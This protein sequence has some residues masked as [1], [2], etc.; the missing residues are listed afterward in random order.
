MHYSFLYTFETYETVPNNLCDAARMDYD[1][2][3]RY[4]IQNQM[5]WDFFIDILKINKNLFSKRPLLAFAGFVPAYL[6]ARHT[7][8][9]MHGR[10][11][12]NEYHKDIHQLPRKLCKAFGD[13][14]IAVTIGVFSSLAIFARDERLRQTSSMFA[15]G[16]VAIQITKKIIKEA[17][18]HECNIR[19]YCGRFEKVK[20]YGGFPSGH[21]AV[22]SFMA[23][24]YGIRHGRRWGIPLGA[25]AIANFGVGLNCN[26]HYASQLIAG[27]ALGTAYAFATLK[28]LNEKYE[29]LDCQIT[30]DRYGKPAIQMTYSY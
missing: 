30:A 12:D 3:K 15:K 14:G 5:I 23:F 26:R 16:V 8:D 13:E 18:S 22:S 9:S 10:F 25:Y 21:M 7:D 2:Q 1:I 27:A 17:T 20:T 24:L 28:T 19:P 6:I 29:H 4:C 11:Y